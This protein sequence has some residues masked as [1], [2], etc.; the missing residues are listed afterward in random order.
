MR[1]KMPG[2]ASWQRRFLVLVATACVLLPAVAAAQGLTGTLS[3]T[4]TDPQGGVLAGAL[5][6]ISSP[7]LIGGQMTQP[8]GERGQLRFAALPP[9]TYILDIELQGFAPYR[10]DD[11]RIGVGGTLNLRVQLRLA[12]VTES[13]AVEGGG[14]RI[15]AREPGFETRF[16]VE[17]LDAIPTSRASMFPW[18]RNAPGISPTSPASSTITT[19]SAFGSGT[20]ENKFLFDGTDFTCPC[21]GI[22]RSEPGI[23]FIREVHVQSVGASV[24]YGNVQGAVINVVTKQG[25]N[26]FQYDA[27]YYGQPSGLTSQPVLLPLPSPASGQ[28]GYSRAKYRDFTTNLGGPAVRERVWFFGGYQHLR[29]YDSQPGTDPTLPRTYEQDK[30]FGKLTWQIAPTWQLVQSFHQ[31]FWLNPEQPLPSTPFEATV[32]RSATVPAITFGHL[33]HTLSSNTVWDVRVGRFVYSQD[34]ALSNGDSTIPSRRDTVT[35]ITSGAPPQ[36]GR[37]EISRTT[38]KATLTH[39]RPGF[40]AADHEWKIGGQVERGEH[41]GPIVIPTGARFVDSNGAKSQKVISAPS[42]T[43]GLFITTA[44]F[45]SDEIT[46]GNRLTINAGL[47]F[48]HHRA[49]SQDLHAVDLDGA[50]TDEVVSGLGTLYTWDL[51][52]PRLGTTTR[53]TADGRTI[54]RGS[55]GRFYQGVLT[56]ELAP[57]HPGA[58]PI[59]TLGYEAATGDYTRPISTVTPDESSGRSR[60]AGAAHRRAIDRRRSRARPPGLGGPRLRPQG[61]RA[62]HWLDGRRGRIRRIDADPGQRQRR[63]G[64][65]PGERA[66]RPTL[67]P[68]QRRA[69]TR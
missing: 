52:S 45:V 36:F 29:D 39:Y 13:V 32:R 10:L 49:V 1:I 17:D 59:T 66:G 22:A 2:A 21:N 65:R 56:G 68:D 24:E 41:E 54:L 18:I 20:N 61:W 31:E 67:S 27:S 4:V 48:D 43:G 55:Y 11:I 14:S 64:L 60:H 69:V 63:A 25:G 16:G 38:A 57:V 47:R 40:L 6:R 37:I 42:N 28:T 50:E 30:I 8:T 23:D 58:T 26:R 51:F 34:N 3:G 12:N 53:L 19:V 62:V 5:V 15:D 9:G 35:G 7:A 44:A 46:I 33:T